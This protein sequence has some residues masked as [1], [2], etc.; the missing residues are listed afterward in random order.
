MEK[1]ENIESS[2]SSASPPKLKFRWEHP[3]ITDTRHRV[4]RSSGISLCLT[5]KK[6]IKLTHTHTL[7][8]VPERDGRARLNGCSFG[9][10]KGVV[11]GGD[12]IGGVANGVLSSFT[13]R[14]RGMGVAIETRE[15]RVFFASVGS[16]FPL[17]SWRPSA[18]FFENTDCLARMPKKGVVRAGEDGWG[19][20]KRSME[21]SSS[22]TSSL[23]STACESD[24]VFPFNRF[25]LFGVF[26]HNVVSRFPR[27]PGVKACLKPQLLGTIRW[28]ARDRR[29][30]T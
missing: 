21:F 25:W 2:I 30:V 1:L 15:R 5:K 24:G 23:L 11:C 20:A 27:H 7:V 4:R 8:Q 12:G 29:H 22:V 19:V 14:A 6:T 16:F 13:S 17:A 3:T 26:V 28:K 9:R 10:K 18:L